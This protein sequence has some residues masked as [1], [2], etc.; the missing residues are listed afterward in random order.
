MIIRFVR[1]PGTFTCG[2]KIIAQKIA[3]SLRISPPLA[4]YECDLRDL[5]FLSIFEHGGDADNGAISN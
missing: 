4:P 5:F 1:P 2:E 3:F